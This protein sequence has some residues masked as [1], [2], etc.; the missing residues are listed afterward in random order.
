MYRL[1]VLLLLVM[2]SCRVFADDPKA[3]TAAVKVVLPIVHDADTIHGSLRFGWNVW[4]MNA[5]L[6]AYG[7]DAWEVT[8]TRQTVEITD[9]EIVKGKAAKYALIE[10]LTTADLYAEDSGQKDPYGRVS[11]ILWVKPH[12]PKDSE[13]IYLASWLEKN[14]HLRTPRNK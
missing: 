7:C 5:D 4:L 11:A 2:P 8:R 14:G 1:L 3:P 13:W 10:L 9:E 6:R 12:D